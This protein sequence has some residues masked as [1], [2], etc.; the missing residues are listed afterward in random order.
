MKYIYNNNKTYLL[1]YIDIDLIR[2]IT[3]LTRINA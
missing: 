3:T 2:M 1:L